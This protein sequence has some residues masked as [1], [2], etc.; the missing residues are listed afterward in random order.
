MFSTG[1]GATAC[2]PNASAAIRGPFC[3]YGLTF[4]QT[5]TRN[6]IPS[7]VW[8]EITYSFSNFKGATVEVW[9]WIS[10][11]IPDLIMDGFTYTCCDWNR[12][13]LVKGAQEEYGKNQPK[14]IDNNMRQREN[15]VHN[16]W[17]VTRKLFPLDDVIM[18]SLKSWNGLFVWL[19][20]CVASM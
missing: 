11:C 6:H 12:S 7:M 2:S 9:Q 4:I 15:W 10:D 5:W 19:F 8:D 1:T 20:S 16:S 13:I 18:Y 17:D 14:S 3:Y